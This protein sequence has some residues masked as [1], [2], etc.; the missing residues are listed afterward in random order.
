M[1]PPMQH[2]GPLLYT[3]QKAPWHQTVREGSRSKEVA[4][5]GGGVKEEHVEGL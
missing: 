3:E 2:A 1:V 4:V 5:S